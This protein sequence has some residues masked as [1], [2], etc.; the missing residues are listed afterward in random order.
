MTAGDR[1]AGTVK[2]RGNTFNI[3]SGFLAARSSLEL[4]SCVVPEANMKGKILS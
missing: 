2:I 1:K 4:D 3:R